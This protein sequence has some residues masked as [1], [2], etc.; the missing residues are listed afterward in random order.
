MSLNS[1]VWIHC[2]LVLPFPPTR[3]TSYPF[4]SSLRRLALLRLLC[5]LLDPWTSDYL[6]DDKLHK[7]TDSSSVEQRYRCG[8]HG[9]GEEE[10]ERE[11]KS[12]GY[13]FTFTST[14]NHSPFLDLLIT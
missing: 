13:G 2:P 8:G 14:W 1:G 11:L 7:Q 12:K 6:T 10:G 4:L 9:E 3:P 5:F